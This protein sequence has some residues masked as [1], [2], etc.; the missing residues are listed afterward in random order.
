MMCGY[1]CS[2]VRTHVCVRAVC[3]VCEGEYNMVWVTVLEGKFANLQ[4][5]RQMPNH[6]SNIPIRTYIIVKHIVICPYVLK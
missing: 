3:D 2:A 4:P 6:A 1:A 5:L